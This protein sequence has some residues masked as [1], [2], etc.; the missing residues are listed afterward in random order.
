[1]KK[2][3]VEVYRT[4]SKNKNELYS[5]RVWGANGELIKEGY[6]SPS[7]ALRGAKDLTERLLGT[8][9]GEALVRRKGIEMLKLFIEGLDE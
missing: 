8:A 3:I 5:F 7:K 1:M 4:K 2:P 6:G 9:W